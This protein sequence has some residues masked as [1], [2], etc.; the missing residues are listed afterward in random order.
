[1][2]YLKRGSK[3][4]GRP[5]TYDKKGEDY[6]VHDHVLDRFDAGIPRGVHHFFE[7]GLARFLDADHLRKLH[8]ALS[9]ADSRRH[10][11]DSC[12]GLMGLQSVMARKNEGPYWMLF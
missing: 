10:E 8:C 6:G 1:M 11:R 12:S 3:K 7:S 4:P 2:V 9:R 5:L